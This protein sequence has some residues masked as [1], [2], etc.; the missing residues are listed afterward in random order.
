MLLKT[1][2]A[3]Y[4]IWRFDDAEA[5]ELLALRKRLLCFLP[6]QERLQLDFQPAV[7]LRGDREY[8]RATWLVGLAAVPILRVKIPS[9]SSRR[10]GRFK[11]F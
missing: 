8:V 3:L 11:K 2:R 4:S 7:D 6:L 10:T 1:L 5:L 9:V